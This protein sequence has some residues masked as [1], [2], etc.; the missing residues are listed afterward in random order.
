MVYIVSSGSNIL[1]F[2]P[3]FLGCFKPLSVTFAG[4]FFIFCHQNPER[5]LYY[6]HGFML[7]TTDAKRMAHVKRWS[8][9]GSIRQCSH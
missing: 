5:T 9:V 8:V 1:L 6:L 3:A 7:C 4:G 2:S